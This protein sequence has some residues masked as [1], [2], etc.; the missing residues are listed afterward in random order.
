[1]LYRT[2]AKAVHPDLA[3][4]PEDRERRT[5]WMA[6]VNIAYQTNDADRLQELWERWQHSP[7]NVSGAGVGADLIRLIR[8]IAQVRARIW[9]GRGGA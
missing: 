6:D 3:T 7:D 8:Q 1:M 4:N 2:L 5:S 9:G